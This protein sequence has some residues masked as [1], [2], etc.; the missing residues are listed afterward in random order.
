MAEDEIDSITDSMDMD[1]S[2][3]QTVED[4]GAWRAA[5]HGAAKSWIWLRT[6]QQLLPLPHALKLQIY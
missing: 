1:L 3:L 4:R 2:K 6:E 5:V